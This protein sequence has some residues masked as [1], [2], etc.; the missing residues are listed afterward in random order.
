MLS[1]EKIVIPCMHAVN[2]SLSE[3]WNMKTLHLK[4]WHAQKKPNLD[5]FKVDHGAAA[6]L[7]MSKNWKRSHCVVSSSLNIHSVSLSASLFE[8]MNNYIQ[9]NVRNKNRDSRNRKFKVTK[10]KKEIFKYSE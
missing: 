7:K 6:A 5:L 10:A 9:L 3:H 1:G 8:E 2:K 4:S